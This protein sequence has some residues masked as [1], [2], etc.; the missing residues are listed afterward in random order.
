VTNRSELEP[1]ASQTAGTPPAGD[2]STAGSSS[3]RGVAPAAETPAGDESR[4]G[5]VGV[6]PA[7]RARGLS[8][9]CVN[10]EREAQPHISRPKGDLS[11]LDTQELTRQTEETCAL[12][13]PMLAWLDEVGEETKADRARRA[14]KLIARRVQIC[15]A[16]RRYRYGEASIRW[17]A[18][19]YNDRARG[20][21]ERIERVKACQTDIIHVSCSACGVGP[22]LAAGCRAWMLC[23]RCRGAVS[24]ALRARFL[25]ARRLIVEQALERNLFRPLRRGG[26]YGER[27]LTLTVPHECPSIGERIGV[28][29]AA[30]PRFLKLFNGYLRD[31]VIRSVEWFRV[32]EWTPGEDGLGHPHFHLWLF[33]PFIDVDLIREWWA[34]AL[35]AEGCAATRVIVDIKAVTDPR[36]AAV[37]LIKYMLKDITASG[38]KIPPAVFA[39]VY[40]A[41]AGRRMRQASEGFIGL[42]KRVSPCCECGATL[43]RTVRIERRSKPATGKP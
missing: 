34:H 41:L 27:F 35:A 4:S 23:V 3:S 9:L 33:S 16:M 5:G 42:A 20:H 37:E 25:A 24:A 11:F 30:W 13:A 6:K 14:Q 22:E 28:A 8:P 1:V 38:E 15:S 39:R 43:P 40:E 10:T 36:T 12:P 7:E 17:R 26:R 29:Y 18:K 21:R 32:F 19:W 2:T 31:R